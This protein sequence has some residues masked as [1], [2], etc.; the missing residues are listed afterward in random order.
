MFA[1]EPG[2]RNLGPQI[3]ASVIQGS[4]FLSDPSGRELVYT[5]VRG[6]PA[7]LL[8]YTVDDKKLIV[9]QPLP[10]ADGAWDLAVSTDGWLYIPGAKGILYRHRPGTQ[11]VENLGIVLPGETT[12]WNLAA[13]K[14]GEMFG[15]TYPGC[16]VFRYHP[17]NGFTDVGKGPLV[18]GENYVRSLVY[19]D[20]SEKLFAGIGSHADLI[21]LDPLTGDKISLLPPQ[22]KTKEF[23]YSLEILQGQADGDRLLA[24]VTNGS[25]TLVYN[26]LTRK[27]EYQITE[28]DMKAVSSSDRSGKFYYTSKSGLYSRNVTKSADIPVKHASNTGSANAML[29][30]GRI[31][32]M[33][34]ADGV[35]SRLD[36]D[37]GEIINTLLEIPGQP[38]SIQAIMKGPDGRIWSGGY[39]AGGHGAYDP[40]KNTTTSYPGLHQT[41]GMTVSG[42]DIYF[43][44]YPKG[45]YYKYDTSR[46]WDLK[47]SNPQLLGQI[48]DQSRS[49][50]VLN[51]PLS[52]KIFF[53]MVPEYGKL[54][55]H[56][57]SYDTKTTELKT[58]GPVS[59]DQS[60]VSLTYA[61]KLVWGGTSVS[62]G[63]GIRPATT[64][65]RLFSWD[66]S[67]GQVVDDLVPVAGANAITAL[68]TAPDGNI[69]GMAGGTLFVYDP[70]LKKIIKSVEL[71]PA[72]PLT[73]HVWRDAFLVW[74]PNGKVYGTGD[75]Q[76]FSID[77]LTFTVEK[78]FKPASLLAMDNNGRLYFH[79]SAELW[80][81]T[82]PN[83]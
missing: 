13:G 1:Q 72:R 71:Y 44:I 27:I 41:E 18:Q 31:L 52:S 76:M 7:H 15:A 17:D 35:L 14:N 22:L 43:G 8:G 48:P 75:N 51:E 69:W 81:Y 63:L 67:K 62:G 82:I 66:V 19:H 56:L 25:F 46:P 12:V 6:N 39:L 77:P 45:M 68:I 10:G 83:P 50:A 58:Y 20:R 4:T 16:R 2:L 70:I 57:V 78:L 73:S 42:K 49:F 59:K 79:R 55:G 3:K 60:I 74:H 9:D 29:T 38:I 33:L 28:M 24:L 40:E 53:G 65:A 80:Q 34:N 64:A 61:N 23:V 5:V 47:A 30:K 21:E 36:T 37:N 11:L 26:L 54:G 32:W